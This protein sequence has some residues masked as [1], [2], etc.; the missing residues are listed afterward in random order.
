MSNEIYNSIQL[1][2]NENLYHIL[3]PVIE[4]LMKKKFPR[5]YME[6]YGKKYWKRSD[7]DEYFAE[8]M[9]EE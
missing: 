1:R 9:K 2:S 4:K 3:I 5:L 6:H 7:I 8:V